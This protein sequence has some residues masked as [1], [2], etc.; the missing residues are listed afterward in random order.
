MSPSP[1]PRSVVGL[2]LLALSLGAPARA[3]YPDDNLYAP[4]FSLRT[5]A[6][7]SVRYPEVA[8]GQPSV[9]MFW[10]AWCPLSLIHI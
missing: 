3:Q 1:S 2:L 4:S 6:G 9:L 7:G 10:P 5:P 8:D